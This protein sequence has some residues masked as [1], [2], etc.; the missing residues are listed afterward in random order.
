[1]VRDG[2]GRRR[3]LFRQI[4]ALIVVEDGEALEE[5]DRVGGVAGLGR[6]LAFAPGNEPVGI[7]NRG[8]TFAFPDM[9]PDLERLA[10]GGLVLAGKAALGAGHPQDQHVDSRI[11]PAGR[12]VLRQAERRRGAG[13]GLD[14]GDAALFELGDDPVGDVLIEAGA[15]GEGFV[16]WGRVRHGRSPRRAGESALSPV[17]P[18]T[19]TR[20][21]LEL[22]LPAIPPERAAT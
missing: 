7:D 6:A 4:L 19:R 2:L 20:C 3:D 15:V 17:A 16:G 21:A 22:S 14:P 10:E 1:M 18:V 13:P 12:G 11:T 5:R 8:A 9:R